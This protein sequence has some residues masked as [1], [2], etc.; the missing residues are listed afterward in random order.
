MLY[1][2][3]T[4]Q[5]ISY[6]LILEKFKGRKII[7]PR[8]LEIHGS[9][10]LQRSFWMHLLFR[11]VPGRFHC[12]VKAMLKLKIRQKHVGSGRSWKLTMATEGQCGGQ[13]F[14]RANGGKSNEK[15]ESPRRAGPVGQAATPAFPFM[16][17]I[18][19]AITLPLGTALWTPPS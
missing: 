8:T 4:C 1:I 3:C 9:S 16:A 17:C 15:C 6:L 11:L 7:L 10:S 13:A 18:H 12:S 14:D 2:N 5:K 19:P